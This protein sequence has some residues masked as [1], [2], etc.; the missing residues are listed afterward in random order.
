MS[1]A[2]TYTISERDYIAAGRLFRRLTRKA[3]MIHLIIAA[4]LLLLAIFAPSA[5]LRGAGVGG[6][7]GGVTVWILMHL[8][9]PWFARRH[10]RTYKAIQQPITIT[11]QE[12]GIRLTAHDYDTL[13]RWS[14]LLKWR[15]NAQF[16][17]I[18]PIPRLFYLV[19]THIAAQGFDLDAL[20]AALKQHIGA[21]ES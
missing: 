7:I 11:L 9:A 14:H 20:K 15:E 16:I 12:D 21:S 5:A 17:L 19:P 6:L 18:Y 8:L 1:Q 4:A 3:L 10:Y 2:A 13:L